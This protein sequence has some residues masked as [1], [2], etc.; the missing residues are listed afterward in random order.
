[1][2]TGLDR[3]TT[4]FGGRMRYWRKAR[5]LTMKHLSARTGIPW[6]Q[7]SHIELGRCSVSLPRLAKIAKALDVSTDV[8]LGLKA[9]PFLPQGTPPVAPRP[10]CT[11]SDHCT[12]CP[13]CRAY[14]KTH[15]SRQRRRPH[16]DRAPR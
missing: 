14:A 7:L 9:T 1:M 2:F 3:D 5:Q 12:P 15:K 13:A 10:S 11:C 8:L 4:T 16:D 6:T